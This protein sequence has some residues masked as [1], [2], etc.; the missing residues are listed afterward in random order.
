MKLGH[1]VTVR[2]SLELR[3]SVDPSI[4][5]RESGARVFSVRLSSCQSKWHLF[6]APRKK[7]TTA[8]DVDGDG[9]RSRN[10]H[11]SHPATRQQGPICSVCSATQLGWVSQKICIFN[12][13]Q[14]RM[15]I[16][17]RE[18][19]IPHCLSLTSRNQVDANF[20]RFS[21]LPFSLY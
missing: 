7:D 3:R 16:L 1:C 11:F 14:M 15:Q 21:P 4:P 20:P 17:Q 9:R 12:S 13:R 2:V 19:P 18:I 5:F 8:P 6:P 10:L